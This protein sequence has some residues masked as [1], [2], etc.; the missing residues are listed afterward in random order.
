MEW[1]NIEDRL[2]DKEGF[3]HC[4]CQ[5]FTKPIK[6]RFIKEKNGRQRNGFSEYCPALFIYRKRVPYVKYWKSK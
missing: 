3:Y 6:C 5:Y 1:V 4:L 2:P